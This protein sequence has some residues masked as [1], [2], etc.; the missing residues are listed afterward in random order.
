MSVWLSHSELWILGASWLLRSWSGA[1]MS[2]R[3]CIKAVIHLSTSTAIGT[4]AVQGKGTTLPMRTRELMGFWHTSSMVRWWE[5]HSIRTQTLRSTNEA[6][7][8]I[9][10][11]LLMMMAS[12]LFLHYTRIHRAGY[13][14]AVIHSMSVTTK[15][16]NWISGLWTTSSGPAMH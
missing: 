7:I 6:G 12:L 10:H 13:H 16:I 8:L 5:V 4:T 14:L 3:P 9:M 1:W 15:G 2:T 11:V